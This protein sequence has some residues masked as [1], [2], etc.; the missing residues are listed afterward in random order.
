[1]VI[2]TYRSNRLALAALHLYVSQEL[3]RINPIE[4]WSITTS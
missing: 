4:A 1:M 3:Y 2:V